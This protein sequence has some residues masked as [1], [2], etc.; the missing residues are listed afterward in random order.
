MGKRA[1]MATYTLRFPTANGPVTT[2]VEVPRGAT[3]LR[4]L[5]PLAQRITQQNVER[6]VSV[7]KK[8]GRA[9]SCGRG[10]AAC[11]R[12]VVPISAPEAFRLADHVI[13]LDAKRRDRI[14]ARIDAVETEIQA[15][16]LLQELDEVRAGT[17]PDRSG[18]AARYFEQQIACP[19]LHEEACAVY[20]DRP[21]VCRHYV[22]TTPAAWC[23]APALHQIRTVP[24]P[25]SWSG[26]LSAAT[27][28]LTGEA[29][30]MIPLSVAMRWVESHADL[31]LLEWPGV[32]VM[33]ALLRALGISEA[34][35]A[36]GVR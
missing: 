35:V 4:D 36:A 11:C 23:S 8:E 33:H 9:V 24:T 3:R 30:E 26:A 1:A 22:V 14:L 5:V 16:G 29:A 17:H 28:A 20:A 18:F 12:Q 31:A 15:A 25:R 27:A 2:Q 32:D 10:C 19:F 34:D 7:E 13:A 6:A 21:L